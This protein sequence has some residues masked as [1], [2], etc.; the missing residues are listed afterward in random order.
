MLA[1]LMANLLVRQER[2]FVRA[3]RPSLSSDPGGWGPTTMS[4][5]VLTRGDSGGAEH[6]EELVTDLIRVPS[7]TAEQPPS[8]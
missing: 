2:V 3:E 4:V 7:L 5:A 1:G 6:L 8:A